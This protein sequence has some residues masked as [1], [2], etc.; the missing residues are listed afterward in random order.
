[1]FYRYVALFSKS[2]AK[3]SSFN[4]GII[5]CR[6]FASQGTWAMASQS[7]EGNRCIATAKQIGLTIP[8]K[9][10]ARIYVFYWLLVTVL[11]ITAPADAQQAGKI[12]RIGFLD[13]STA[14]GIALLS[15][16]FRQ[17]LRNLGWIEGKN[18]TL[19]YRFSEGNTGRL[20][21]LAADLVRLNVDLI[22]T[23][24]APPVREAKK[25]TTTIPIVMANTDENPVTFP[26]RLARLATMPSFTGF[27]A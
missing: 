25:A 24:G 15:D 6:S 3:P 12:F 5:G 8:P 21:D 17:E 27:G 19:E 13:N 2:W 18:I 20:A 7:T 14:P 22:V 23:T 9:V 26:P 16:A 1:M 11:L 4:K 10:L